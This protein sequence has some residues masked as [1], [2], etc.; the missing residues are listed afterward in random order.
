MYRQK[1]LFF[2]K[3]PNKNE[4]AIR[5]REASNRLQHHPTTV[6]VLPT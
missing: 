3:N 6:S 5:S 4:R 2:K 1:N